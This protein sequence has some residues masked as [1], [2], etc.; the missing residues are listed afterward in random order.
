VSRTC[1]LHLRPG[2]DGESD[3]ILGYSATIGEQCSLFHSRLAHIKAYFIEA[4]KVKATGHFSL[5]KRK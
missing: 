2:D 5:V 3:A 4:R 1:G